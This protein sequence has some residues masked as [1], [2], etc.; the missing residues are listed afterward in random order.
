MIN[1]EINGNP[2]INQIKKYVERDTCFFLCNLVWTQKSVS[3]NDEASF[4]TIECLN[5]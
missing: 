1:D 4:I 5:V 3:L 2:Y